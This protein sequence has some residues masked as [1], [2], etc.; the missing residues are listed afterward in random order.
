MRLLILSIATL[1]CNIS[2]VFSQDANYWTSTYGPGGYFMPGSVVS[3][4]GDSGVLFYNPA[5]LAYNTKN[6]VSVSGTLYQWESIR[7]KDG[8]GKGYNLNFSTGSVVPMI[9][10]NTLYLKL[11]KPI[12]IAYAITHTPVMSFETSQR[13][14]GLVNALDDSYSPGPETYIG[15][16]SN[17]NSI[18]ETVGTLS[19]GIGLTPKLKVGVA[20]EGQI[21]KQSILVDFKIRAIE[22]TSSNPTEAPIVS[23]GEYL[24]ISSSHTALRFKTGLAYELSSRDHLGLMVSSPLVRIAGKATLVSDDIINNLKLAGGSIPL[25]LLASTRQ[26]KLHT[27][28]KM[29]L[30]IA[31]G[32][33]HDFTKGQLYIAGEFFGKIKE[34]NTVTPRDEA[35]ERPDTGFRDPASVLLRIK[36]VRRAITNVAVGFSYPLKPATTGFISFRTDFSYADDDLYKDDDGTPFNT[37][38]WN[39]YHCEAGLNVKKRRFNLK[40]GILLSYGVTD[41]YPQPL[42]FSDPSEENFLLGNTGDTRARRFMAGIVFAYVHN[43]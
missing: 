19:V 2:S 20:F 34:Y 3:F 43:L 26:T 10:S 32:Y 5:L 31:L 28:W 25:Y 4:N 18:N 38:Y 35:Y 11:K 17:A 15:Q 41:Q 9:A 40:A 37:S 1:L 24:G 23:V 7:I 12:S 33:T 29:P 42:D 16:Y 14:D 36:D 6:A 8:V 22:N 21:R 27:K 39:I 30:S 13:R